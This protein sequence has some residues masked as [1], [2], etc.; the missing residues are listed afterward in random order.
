MD[1]ISTW[2]SGCIDDNEYTTPEEKI[3]QFNAITREQV[4]AAAE[5]MKLDTI[6]ILTSREKQA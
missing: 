2:I 6:Y 4:I 5:S 1:S 3:N